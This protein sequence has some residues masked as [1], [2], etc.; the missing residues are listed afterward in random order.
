MDDHDVVRLGEDRSDRAAH[1]A[2]RLRTLATT[3]L[4]GHEI[5]AIR[6]LMTA[7]FGTEEDER[8]SDDDWRHALGGTHFVLELGAEIVSH[9]S[10]VEREVHVD[11]RPLRTGYVEAV[12]TAPDR[13]GK[14][15]GSVVMDAVGAHIRAGFEL[16][17]LGTG[18]HRFYER[19][20]LG[21]VAGS[22]VGSDARWGRAD[23]RRRRL[24]H[25]PRDPDVAAVRP[26]R[27]DQL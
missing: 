14:G 9:A 20:R 7:A 22:I 16:G 3:D 17:A 19:P 2:P 23:P 6:A 25:G 1:L 10:V 18:R 26:E 4:T 5:D 24:H 11:G 13:Q 8:F 27:T 12:A 15:Y 21:E